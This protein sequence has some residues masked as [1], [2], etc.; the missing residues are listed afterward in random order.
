MSVFDAFEPV[1]FEHQPAA[2]PPRYGF[3]SDA[4]TAGFK[5][6]KAGT[7]WGWN[8][9]MY[10]SDIRGAFRGG[11]SERGI[12]VAPYNEAFAINGRRLLAQGIDPGPELAKAVEGER[13]FWE[14]VAGERKRD[15]SFLKDYSDVSGPEDIRVAALNRRARDEGEAN[16]TYADSSGMGKAA[17]WLGNL[18]SGFR[19][20][21]TYL[22]LGGGLSKGATLG[23]TILKTAGREALINAGAQL[24]VEPLVRIDAANRGQDRTIKDTALDVGMAGV[25]GGVLGAA[26]AGFDHYVLTREGLDATVAAIGQDNLTPDA[27]AAVHVLDR[28]IDV[29]EASPFEATPAGDKEHGRRLAI[30]LTSLENDMPLPDLR[31]RLRSGSSMSAISSSIA[32]AG[33]E[34]IKARIRQF[35]SGGNPNAKNPGAG[36]SASGLYQFIDSTALGL[37]RQMGDERPKAEILASKNDPAFQERLMDQALSNY[38]ETFERAGVEVTPGNLYLAHFLGPEKAIQVAMA[39]RSMPIAELVGNKAVRANK[40][41]LEGKTVGDVVAEMDRRMAGVPDVKAVAAPRLREDLFLD[42]DVRI[43]AQR[44]FDADIP[45]RLE[46]APEP[47]TLV[48]QEQLPTPEALEAGANLRS[49]A[50]RY[51]EDRTGAME[52]LD[53]VPVEPDLAGRIREATGIDVQGF[54]H[55][56]DSGAIRHWWKVHGPEGRRVPLDSRAMSLDDLQRIP[57][58]LSAPD[59]VTQGRSP[60]Q[61]GRTPTVQFSKRIGDEYFYVEEIRQPSGRLAFKTFYVKVPRGGDAVAPPRT[62]EALAGTVTISETANERQPEIAQ[63]A[64]INRIVDEGASDNFSDPAGADAKAQTESALHDLIND[65]DIAMAGDQMRFRFDEDGPEVDLRS[66][67]DRI[68]ADEAAITAARNCL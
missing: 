7:D 45:F 23:S 57:E 36:Q 3:G 32:G 4:L 11:L 31:T 56:A 47:A 15:P 24:A 14:A 46:T 40:A 66:A 16:A 30:A 21:L 1:E 49:F 18:G 12:H 10:E 34:G 53:L 55:S 37:A 13:R 29:R 42:E 17:W 65:P 5:A 28:L 26:D 19:D 67:L 6:G 48:Q 8:Q 58:I 33:D 22:P 20:P 60:S 38:R 35:E 41:L 50:E 51:V 59:N 68:A 25:L 9:S 61:Q 2:A 64:A 63:T 54:T 44:D 43:A 62:P 27:R 39:D 52:P